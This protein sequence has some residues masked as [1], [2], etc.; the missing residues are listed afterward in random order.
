MSLNI[1]L[2]ESDIFI[3][4]DGTVV[5]V[6]N[7]IKQAS[8]KVV[9]ELAIVAPRTTAI[10][11]MMMKES[12]ETIADKVKELSQWDNYNHIQKGLDELLWDD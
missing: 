12:E 2:G 10:T 7:F 8:G 6:E 1:T 4:S 11:R 5:K 3:T 9:V